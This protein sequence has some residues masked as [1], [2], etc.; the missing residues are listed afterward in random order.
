M[1]APAII[2]SPLGA[3]S[4][5]AYAVTS[6]VRL[7]SAPDIPTFAEMG[8]PALSFSEWGGLFAPKG[9]PK[10]EPR[11]PDRPPLPL[12]HLRPEHGESAPRVLPLLL[13]NHLSY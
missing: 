12:S 4:I 2:L 5:W 11:R 9:T 3:G 8:L 10:P 6:D 1:A 13:Q 7:A